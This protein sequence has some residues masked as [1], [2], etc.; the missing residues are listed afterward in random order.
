[1]AF[2]QFVAFVCV[3]WG[4]AS[5]GLLFAD[6]A[7]EAPAQAAA[8]THKDAPA[9]Q[10]GHGGIID[11]RAVRTSFDESTAPVEGSRPISS[12]FDLAKAESWIAPRWGAAE[13]ELR[14][15]AV[16][17]G[18]EDSSQGI[19]ENSLVMRVNRAWAG[20][21]FGERADGSERQ[22]QVVVG[23]RAGLIA[24]PWYDQ[25]EFAGKHR[26]IATSA[27][28]RYEL[29]PRSDIGATATVTLSRLAGAVLSL[30]VLN[31][32]GLGQREQNNAKTAAA[33][34]RL[35]VAHFEL[36]GESVP[37]RVLVLAQEGSS[38]PAASADHRLGASL[39]TASRHAQIGVTWMAA[40]QLDA[41]GITRPWLA[42]A[43][44]DVRLWHNA[45]AAAGVYAQ[46]A[47]LRARGQR[48]SF[49]T[50]AVGW[51]AL[52]Q[53]VRAY[54]G[55][56]TTNVNNDAG[57]LPGAAVGNSWSIIIGA[58]AAWDVR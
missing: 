24:H 50:T 22:G 25:S 15:E 46:V 19:A 27:P 31:G 1:M 18:G 20:A 55:V 41:L 45:S 53:A 12:T 9:L 2:K 5:P 56:Q 36:G 10:V 32:E 38:G 52:P 44:A 28:E 49:E 4:L 48:V 34:L 57:P 35:D 39:F 14:L 40:E 43:H 51:V 7:A 8:T 26:D 29:A 16:R 23:I 6:E 13:A 37:L 3:A 58:S 30:T 33:S 54:A 47:S 21:V 17:S 42:S 11:A